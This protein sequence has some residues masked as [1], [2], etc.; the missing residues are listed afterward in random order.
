MFGNN[1]KTISNTNE[2]LGNYDGVYGV[3]T[4][5][6]FNA[7]RCL[8]TACKKNNLDVIVVVLGADSKKIRT[9]DSVKVLN[10]IFSNY[11]RIDISNIIYEEFDKFEN[12]FSN[13]ITIEKSTDKPMIELYEIENT[14][15]P[16]QKTELNNISSEIYS[17]NK[18]TSPMMANTKIGQINIKV[19]DEILLSSN[20]LL[21]NNI[22]RK[23][24]KIYYQEIL[25]NFFKV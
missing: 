9:L 10:Y 2:L 24:W 12:Y 14:V 19:N 21:K 3:K 11:T 13:N 1:T 5:F 25:Q 8:V 17:L 15:L 7:G 22:S 18:L 20:I 23:T 6:T 16:L 4:G